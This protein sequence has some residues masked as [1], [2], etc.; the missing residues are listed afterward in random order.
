MSPK[1]PYFLGTP[2]KSSSGPNKNGREKEWCFLWVFFFSEKK[3]GQSSNFRS[4][5]LKGCRNHLVQ[6]RKY[7]DLP[8]PWEEPMGL[9]YENSSF[10]LNPGWRKKGGSLQWSVRIPKKTTMN[11]GFFMSLMWLKSKVVGPQTI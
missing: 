6:A 9:A 2:A 11:Q 8:N 5:S 10:P 7:L 3:K 4:D 1:A